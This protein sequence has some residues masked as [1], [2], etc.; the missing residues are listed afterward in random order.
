MRNGFLLLLALSSLG[1]QTPDSLIRARKFDEAKAIQTAQL[2]KDKNDHNAMYWMG[3]IE[4]AQDRHTTAIDWLEK[5]IRINDNVAAYHYW[6]GSAVA[7]RIDSVATLRQPF[8]AKRIKNEFLRAV[9]LDPKMIEPRWGLMEFYSE[10]P[11]IAG[12]SMEKARE[13]V[14]ELKKLNPYR[15]HMAG[16][17]LAREG[18][19]ADAV[20]EEKELLG[21]IAI[22]P[23][24]LAAYWNLAL[25]YRRQSKWDESFG[26]YEKIMK[27]APDQIVAHLGWG[28][29]AA[30]SGKSLD[31]GEREI[32]T[33][34]ETATIEKQGP[35]NMAAAHFR[36]GM[37]YEKT[38]RKDLAKASYNETLKINPKH[39]DAKKALDGLK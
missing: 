12:G 2:A 20:A 5:A 24:S 23:D 31:R 11:G 1:A 32:K 17:Q 14:A 15:G 39:A 9:E 10:A 7:G 19:P 29:T 34:L 18:K 30:M 22:A 21:A 27:V 25:A 38:A 37:I 35:G 26:V 28:G 8:F 3:R 36:L 16:A 33:F 13:Q 6:L 4:E